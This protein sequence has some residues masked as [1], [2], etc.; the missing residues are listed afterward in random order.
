M[1]RRF[2]GG[3][4]ALLTVGGGAWGQSPRVVDSKAHRGEPPRVTVSTFEGPGK[5]PAEISG[6]TE[7][8]D[9][10]APGSAK[11]TDDPAKTAVSKPAI[12]TPDKNG[13]CCPKDCCEPCEPC[14]DSACPPEGRYWVRGD[15]LLWWL[16]G[17]PLPPLVTTSPPGTPRPQAGVLGFPGTVVLFP[18]DSDEENPRSGFRVTAGAWLDECRTCGIEAYFFWLDDEGRTFN[19]G[20]DGSLILARPFFNT[21]TGLPDAQL[22]AFP[23]VL[24][25]SKSVSAGTTNFL[26]AGIDAYHNLCCDCCYR[27]DLIYGYRYLRLEDEL[28]VSESLTSIDPQGIVP[29]GTTISLTDRFETQND[30]HGGEIGA[31]AE[32]WCGDLSLRLLGKVALG[33]TRQ[34]VDISGTTII[35]VPG[36]PPAQFN[37]GLLALGT[38]IGSYSRNEFTVVPEAGLSIG[39]Q[40]TC[41]IRAMV[42][43]S[44]IYWSDVVRPGDQVDLVIN[45]TQ[46]PPGTLQGPARPAFT[47]KSSDFWAQGVNF[48]LEFRY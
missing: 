34:R 31:A 5:T 27:V 23:G 12:V 14:C 30:F 48:G 3:M 24:A 20:S 32:F 40:L 44:L 11:A 4:L 25:G 9:A 2:L 41:N 43:Y 46:L 10:K 39:Y 22:D 35:T 8:P 21:Q 1:D 33:S 38:N 45:P 13:V 29:L 47:F 36:A 17:A 37:G 15:Y 42:G 6:I 7:V 28:I 19:A 16:K 26:G 18:G